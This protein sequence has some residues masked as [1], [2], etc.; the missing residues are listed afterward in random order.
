VKTRRLTNL[1]FI[2]ALLAM[3]S[4]NDAFSQS[5]NT[6]WTLVKDSINVKFYYSTALCNS[7]E[8]ILYKVANNNAS[9]IKLNWTV[10]GMGSKDEVWINANEERAGSCASNKNLTFPIPVGFNLPPV[11]PIAFTVFRF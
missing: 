5:T 11:L 8:T 6:D 3:V 1:T 7:T 4:T 9:T 10:W 2:L